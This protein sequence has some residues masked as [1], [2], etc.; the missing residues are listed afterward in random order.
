MK[1]TGPVGP[2]YLFSG[3]PEYRLSNFSPAG[4]RLL[5]YPLH[6][7]GAANKQLC[8]SCSSTTN[9]SIHLRTWNFILILTL[10]LI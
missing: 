7:L 3:M 2:R 1:A 10:V 8:S 6:I 5:S 4:W 9:R